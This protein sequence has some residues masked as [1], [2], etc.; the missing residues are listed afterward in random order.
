MQR[1]QPSR[2]AQ[3]AAEHRAAHQILES[4]RIFRD[5]LA[6]RM[7]A[8]GPD[9]IARRAELNPSSR[10][11][12][13]FIAVRTHFAEESLAR[14]VEG[15]VRQLVILGAGLDTYAYRGSLRDRVRIFE[16]DHPAT[17]AW[18]RQRLATAGIP[19]PPSLTF[20]PIDFERES[21]SAG[22]VAVGFDPTQQTLFFWLGVV[23]YLTEDAVDSTLLFIGS[24]PSGAHVVFDYSNP[25]HTLSPEA[26]VRHE[27]RAASVSAVGEGWVSYFESSELRAKLQAFGF[28][29]IEDLGPRGIYSRYFSGA[30]PPIS[31]K[32]GH[33]LRASTAWCIA[34]SGGAEGTAT[35]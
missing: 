22:L 2:T 25:P 23:P 33:I 10:R 15:G 16:V 13:L 1:G 3:A 6:V 14:A 31:D 21:L 30:V 26:R 4:G 28:S 27:R 32:G 20:A 24:L 7:L 11:M 18:K 19:A 29:E 34:C 9:A 8:E 5:P 12:R 17:Q 35:G